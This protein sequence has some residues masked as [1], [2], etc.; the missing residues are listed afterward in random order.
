AISIRLP[1]YNPRNPRVWFHRVEAVFATR[2]I[3]SQV[4]L[5]SYVVQHPPCDV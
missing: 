5:F 2:L 3:A 4:T 1:D